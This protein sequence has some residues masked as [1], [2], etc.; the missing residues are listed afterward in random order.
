MYPIGFR[1]VKIN[2]KKNFK[3][4][5]TARTRT[6]RPPLFIFIDFNLSRQYPSRE[7]VDDPLHGGDKTAPEHQSYWPSNQF[8]TDIY[9]IGNLVR[10]R[11]MTVCVPSADPA[12]NLIY[13]RNTG[14]SSSWKT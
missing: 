13:R 7:V 3:G 2:R 5:A 9:H 11:F 8:H 4:K 12:D 14:V 10:D 1:P 6:L